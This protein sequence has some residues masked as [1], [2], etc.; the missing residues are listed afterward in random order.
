M[1]CL[2]AGPSRIFE[3]S[4]NR[5]GEPFAVGGGNKVFFTGTIYDDVAFEQ[6]GRHPDCFQHDQIVESELHKDDGPARISTDSQC[7]L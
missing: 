2:S 1:Y 7:R 6:D 5:V 4:A 3:D